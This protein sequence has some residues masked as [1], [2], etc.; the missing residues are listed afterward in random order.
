VPD[1][2]WR[3]WRAELKSGVPDNIAISEVWFDASKYLVGDM[4]DSTMNYIFRNSVLDYA[5]GGDARAAYR[6]LELLRENYPP[7]ALHALMNL[8]S[9]HDTARSLHL[10]GSKEDASDAEIALAKQRLRL[11]M[12]FQFTYPGAP[13]IYYGDEV[14]VTGGED[15]FN[16][17]TYPW[18]DLGGKPDLG[19]RDYVSFLAKLRRD[20]PVLSHG[21]LQAPIHLDEHVV[22]LL[23]RDGDAWAITAVNNAREDAT[24]RVTLPPDAPTWWWDLWLAPRGGLSSEGGLELHIPAMSGTV[25]TNSRK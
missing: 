14:G 10:F 11:A 25:L 4:F 3:E 21:S 9:T 7:Q 17:G 15:P 22:V 12:F 6:N 24:V 18:A 1:D 19:L 2:F 8:L 23:R 5:N 13:T 16:R 20:N